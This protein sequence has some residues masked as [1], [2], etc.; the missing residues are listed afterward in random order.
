MTTT[1]PAPIYVRKAELA[2]ILSV[3]PRT[4]DTWIAQRVIPVVAPSRK[5]RLFDIAAVKAA[6]EARFG[7]EADCR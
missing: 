7:V 3:S 4:I 6:L 2:K 1:E 5:L